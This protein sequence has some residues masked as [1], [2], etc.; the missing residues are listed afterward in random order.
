M[1]RWRDSP[2]PR[3]TGSSKRS[4]NKSGRTTVITDDRATAVATLPVVLARRD[5]DCAASTHDMI[6]WA[7]SRRAVLLSKLR[8]CGAILLRDFP[9]DGALTFEALA[10][11][12]CD[13]LDGYV[14]G[15]SPRT[16]VQGSVFT[17]TEYSQ[18]E[19]ISMHNEGSY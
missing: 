10:R 1:W 2:K 3:S 15:N 7:S 19:K 16:R 18:V 12:F 17:T 5:D 8:H 11:V 9:I 13:R 4:H 14:G 6:A